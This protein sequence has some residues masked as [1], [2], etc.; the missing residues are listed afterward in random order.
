[1][2]G[3]AL[4]GSANV[5]VTAAGERDQRLRRLV[6]SYLDFIGRVLHNAGTP[7]SEIEDCVQRTFIIASKRLDDI[8]HGAE[9]SFLVQIALNVAAHARR[10]AARR[11]EAPAEELPD[12]VDG[13]TPEQ[14]TQ[15]KRQRQLLDGILDQLEPEL[16][17]VF[18]LYEFEE[19]T[20]AEIAV[21]L[22]IPAGTVAS[23][24][25]RART[26]FRERV[27]ALELARKNEVSR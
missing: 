13:R 14:L 15:Q 21:V 1:M 6:D 11:R 12:V 17:N 20:M 24:L 7:T 18:V 19:M 10:S 16:R 26:E 8:R 3:V 5:T 25:R 2:L 27:R 23:R 9:K 22:E 4:V